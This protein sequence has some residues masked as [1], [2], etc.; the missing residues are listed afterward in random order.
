LV[1]EYV[2]TTVNTAVSVC[3][4]TCQINGRHWLYAPTCLDGAKRRFRM[5]DVLRVNAQRNAYANDALAM[6]EWQQL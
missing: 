1:A 4:P 6:Q 5:R 2:F 3:L